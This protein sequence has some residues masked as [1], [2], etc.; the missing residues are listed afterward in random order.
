MA[1]YGLFEAD[2]TAGFEAVHSSSICC[3]Q[4][5]KEAGSVGSGREDFPAEFPNWV[6]Q[7]LEPCAGSC[8]DPGVLDRP[9]MGLT[10][11]PCWIIFT[12]H[13]LHTSSCCND[14]R[15]HVRRRRLAVVDEDDCTAGIYGSTFH[16]LV[17]QIVT[18]AL[19]TDL[20]H[21]ISIETEPHHYIMASIMAQNH[22][23]S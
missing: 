1:R 22:T 8:Q 11:D 19:V 15:S 4:I 14:V 20:V 6:L 9:K 13:H 2:C 7:V 23:T 5:W 21:V 3:I 12:P 18:F 16:R 10:T 17:I